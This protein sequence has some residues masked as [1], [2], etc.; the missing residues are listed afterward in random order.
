MVVIPTTI[1]TAAPYTVTVGQAGTTFLVPIIAATASINLPTAAAA[2]GMTFKFISSGIQTHVTSIGLASAANIS[3]LVWGIST[4]SVLAVACV[5]K[6]TV[7]FTASA[8]VGDQITFTSDGTNWYVV[9]LGAAVS[10]TV[11]S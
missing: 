10:F 6:S 4:G 7:N 11:T 2:N 3:G 1:T 8:I 9:A 5:G